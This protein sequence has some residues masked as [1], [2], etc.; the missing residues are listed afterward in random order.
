MHEEHERARRQILPV[1]VEDA[2][3]CPLDFN[4]VVI[5]G[6]VRPLERPESPLE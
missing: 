1:T 5:D 6:V 3:A 4:E 2:P